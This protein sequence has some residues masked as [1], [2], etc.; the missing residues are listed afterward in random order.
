MSVQKSDA[1]TS[2]YRRSGDY[3]AT[4]A[5]VYDVS[6]QIDGQPIPIA[7]VPAEFRTM[8]VDNDVDVLV[9][10]VQSRVTALG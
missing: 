4:V 3:T 6:F 9:R 10:E 5:I 7:S 1:C 2:E 8:T